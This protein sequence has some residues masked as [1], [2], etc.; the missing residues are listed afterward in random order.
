VPATAALGEATI[1]G[2]TEN[3]TFVP[4]IFAGELVSLTQ[5]KWSPA[6]E[7]AATVKLADN[8]PLPSIE[9]DVP[10][11]KNADPD[12]GSGTTVTVQEREAFQPLPVRSTVVPGTFMAGLAT[13]IGGEPVET[14]GTAVP[15]FTVRAFAPGT[16]TDERGTNTARSKSTTAYEHVTLRA[17]N[18]EHVLMISLIW[19]T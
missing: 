6:R 9:Q 7:P 16:L 14:L 1:L 3:D 10:L 18:F 19:N 13:T 4:T 8:F 12:A 11:M 15:T 5:R 2:T 17:V